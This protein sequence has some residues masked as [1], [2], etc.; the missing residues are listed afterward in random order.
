MQSG[1]WRREKDGGKRKVE[2]REG[3]RREGW[4]KEVLEIDKQTRHHVCKQH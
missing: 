4:R 3:W 1:D 2:E